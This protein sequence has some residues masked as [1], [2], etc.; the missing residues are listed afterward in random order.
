MAAASQTFS[1]DIFNPIGIVNATSYS[2][3]FFLKIGILIRWNPH[4]HFLRKKAQQLRI[5]KSI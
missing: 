2:K 1:I 3:L 4:H 5:I